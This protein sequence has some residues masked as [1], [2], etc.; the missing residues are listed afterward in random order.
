MLYII[1]TFF[2]AVVFC[3]LLWM[4]YKAA[5]MVREKFGWA[6]SLLLIVGLLSFMQAPEEKE[7]KNVLFLQ[8]A[9]PSNSNPNQ[10]HHSTVLEKYPLFTLHLDVSCNVMPGGKSLQPAKVIADQYGLVTAH[11]WTLQDASVYYNIAKQQ[12]EY[13]VYGTVDWKLL[14][15]PF[16]AQSKSF[17][18]SLAVP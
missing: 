3:L 14:G 1:W 6:A 15:I 11:N 17:A 10:V 16:Y 2:N 9:Y 13:K 12:L 8:S 7:E 5:G 18:G 4:A